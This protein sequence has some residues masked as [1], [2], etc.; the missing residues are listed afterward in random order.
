MTIKQISLT[1]LSLVFIFKTGLAEEITPAT[2]KK[3][4]AL[5]MRHTVTTEEGLFIDTHT[6]KKKLY[7]AKDFESKFQRLENAHG[8]LVCDCNIPGFPETVKL[9]YYYDCLGTKDF[10][11]TQPV[12]CEEL[13]S[14]LQEYSPESQKRIAE[15]LSANK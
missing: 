14:K 1:L 11:S 6:F 9:Y 15:D 7:V 10:Y 12:G 8:S 13:M 4:S 2:E 3:I 5:L